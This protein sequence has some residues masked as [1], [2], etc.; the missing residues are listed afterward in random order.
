MNM[1]L[2]SRRYSNSSVNELDANRKAFNL[3]QWNSWRHRC[4]VVSLYVPFG[5]LRVR[6]Y[7]IMRAK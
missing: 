1:P 4:V 5:E 7:M 2:T 6:V 3:T